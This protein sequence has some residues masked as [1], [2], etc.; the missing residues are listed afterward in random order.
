MRILA[1]DFGDARTGLAT[2]DPLETLATPAGCIR[3]KNFLKVLE[4]VA[5][6]AKKE[7]CESVV[8]GYPKNMDGSE[9]ARAQKCADFAHQLA[10]KVNVPVE[11]F[12][13][14]CSTM[15]AAH[16]LDAS[17]SFGKKR[18]EQIDTASATVILEDYLRFRANRKGLD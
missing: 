3:E 11:L 14:R 8:V 5:E 4:A 18:K 9:G 12:D 10:E 2:C 17:G 13:E 6:F 15:A 16:L 1:V 7:C